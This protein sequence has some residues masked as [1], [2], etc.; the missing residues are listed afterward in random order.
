MA[1]SVRGGIAVLALLVALFVAVLAGPVRATSNGD[2]LPQSP[3]SGVLT[4]PA[5]QRSAGFG[6]ADC[7][8]GHVHIVASFEGF[9]GRSRGLSIVSIQ[10]NGRGGGYFT[11]HLNTSH[12]DWDVRLA[13]FGF[14]TP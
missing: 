12:H 6:D 13:W 8:G 2:S 5:G 7:A 14:K 3:C 1:R 4:I 11:I 9:P 10:T